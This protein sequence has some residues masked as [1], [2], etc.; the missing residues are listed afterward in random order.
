MSGAEWWPISLP[1]S[2]VRASRTDD[3]DGDEPLHAHHGRGQHRNHPLGFET[4]RDKHLHYHFIFKLFAEFRQ[5]NFMYIF[6]LPES[7]RIVAFSTEMKVADASARIYLP[8]SIKPLMFT[9]NV[10]HK[11]CS[12][13]QHADH[14]VTFTI[15]ALFANN[16]T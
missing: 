5:L 2:C 11:I 4:S 7:S 9:P 10:L 13:L 1:L 6:I 12:Q 14:V 8:P 15:C 3:H 16:M